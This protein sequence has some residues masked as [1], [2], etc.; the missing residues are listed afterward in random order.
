[1]KQIDKLLQ[2]GETI[3]SGVQP[4][5][6][7]NFDKKIQLEWVWSEEWNEYTAKVPAKDY[8]GEGYYIIHAIKRPNYCDRGKWYVLIEN[9]GIEALDCAEGFPR[10]YFKIENLVD[11]M[12][13]W[14]NERQSVV[15]FH[16]DK[17]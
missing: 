2:A 15:E 17:K 1:M 12:E 8:N 10:Y 3:A 7:M 9:V 4:F 6:I 16:K 14:I 11:E 13:C 5:H